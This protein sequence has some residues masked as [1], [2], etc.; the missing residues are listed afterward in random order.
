LAE[1]YPASRGGVLRTASLQ[2]A[3]IAVAV[4]GVPPGALPGQSST[5]CAEAYKSYLERL[6]TAHI[7]PERRAALGRWARRVYNACDTGDLE[8]P[9]T[10]FERLERQGY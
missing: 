8:N 9:T 7:S 2:V 5:D 4:F 3:A 6:E 1:E 10:L